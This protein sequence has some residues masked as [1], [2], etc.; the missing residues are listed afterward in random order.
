MPVET[1]G[2]MAMPIAGGSAS[3]VKPLPVYI[4][5]FSAAALN[6]G[7]IVR[8]TDLYNRDD[9]VIAAL[10]DGPKKGALQTA[11]R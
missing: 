3:F 6:D 9:E 2:S 5:Y 11:A 10:L 1:P 7:T 4:V 8:Y